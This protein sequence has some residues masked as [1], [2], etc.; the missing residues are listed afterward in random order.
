MGNFTVTSR[1]TF[2]KLHTVILDTLLRCAYAF[3]EVLG[4]FYAPQNIFREAYWE[5]M[6][7]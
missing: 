2:S 7:F 6:W 5:N 4:H 1:L 3:L